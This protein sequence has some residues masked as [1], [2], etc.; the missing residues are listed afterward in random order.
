[1]TKRETVSKLITRESWPSMRKS[2]LNALL[3]RSTTSL[4]ELNL[5]MLQGLVPAAHNGYVA[6][7]SATFFIL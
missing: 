1:M 2:I 4:K 7:M 6:K 3:T 5:G